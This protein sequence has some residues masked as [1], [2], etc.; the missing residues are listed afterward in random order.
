VR[1]LHVKP[2]DCEYI[3]EII[4]GIG[5]NVEIH[6]APG[7]Y[8]MREAFDLNDLDKRNIHIIG[9]QSVFTGHGIEVKA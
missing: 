9:E 7:V 6:C 1:K 5:D 3:Q 2:E 4:D 8:K